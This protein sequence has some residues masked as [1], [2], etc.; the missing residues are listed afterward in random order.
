MSKR[1]KYYPEGSNAV[2]CAIEIAVAAFGIGVCFGIS[3]N[4]WIWLFTK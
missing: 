3:F 1:M 2:W 4:S